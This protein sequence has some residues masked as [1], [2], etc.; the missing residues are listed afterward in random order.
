MLVGCAT[1]RSLPDAQPVSGVHPSGFVDEASDNFHGKQLARL[2]YDLALCASCHGDDF[3]GGT[4]KVS[5]RKC[6]QDGPDACKTCHGDGPTTGLHTRH[7]AA[8]QA[9]SE[10]HVVPATWDAA[11][12]VR[13]DALP[14]EVTF[15]ALANATLNPADRHGPATY[16]NGTCSNVY[17]HGG[18]LHAGGG[19]ASEPRWDATPTGGCTSCH[20]APP[21]SHAQNECASCH[22]S[23]PH[24][25]GV[26]E[27]G[28][29]CNGCHR[30]TPVFANLAGST[31]TTD[32][33]VGAHQAHLTG[34][35]R[36]RAPLACSEC[37]RVPAQVTDAGHIDSALPAEVATGVGWN[38][39]TAS[40]VN[41]CHGDATPIWTAND[42]AY[43]GSC[44]GIPPASHPSTL[45]LQD[46][47]TCHPSV[48]AF[49]N[50]LF[51]L[52]GT[53]R[54]LDGVI[55]VF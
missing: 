21:P 20:G 30:S 8:G 47:A 39:A 4:A 26:L 31:L 27:V 23:A 55:D 32:P 15:G 28:G 6:H 18:V 1:E 33:V 44:H 25:D 29:D 7:R 48:D 52:A 13:G 54:H 9:C 11:G 43:C 36:L 2:G 24:L 3:A 51:D 14:A 16:A 22:K 38:R 42:Q 19:T 17:C 12:H 10:C 49:G 46:C 37:H 41:A 34:A 53:S 45:T 5:C 50:P 35:A 40:C